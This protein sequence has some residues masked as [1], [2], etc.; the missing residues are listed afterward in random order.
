MA[1]ENHVDKVPRT[2]LKGVIQTLLVQKL[3]FF[4]GAFGLTFLAVAARTRDYFA[5]FVPEPAA[6]WAVIFLAFAV[7]GFFLA[8][9]AFFYFRPRF[10]HDSEL[11]VF[12]ELKTGAY[13]C[14]RCMIKEK[15]KSP[16][17]D[18]PEKKGWRCSACGQRIMK[19][20][21]SGNPSRR[22]GQGG[23]QGWMAR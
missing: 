1:D 17:R 2:I 15:R 21:Y 6:P 9:S 7:C 4:A 16:L 5:Q 12:R 23:P 18:L 8:L 13:F 14:A 10:K 3:A 20:E 11:G 19:P 22:R